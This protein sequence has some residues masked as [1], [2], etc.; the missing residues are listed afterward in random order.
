MATAAATQTDLG[1]IEATIQSYFDGLYEGDTDKLGAA[2]HAFA[3]LYSVGADG[4]A[5]DL[6]LAEW[7]EMVRNRPSAASKG[8]ARDDRIVSVDQSGPGTAFVKVRCQSRPATSPTTCL[9]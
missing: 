6:P 5:A 1:A 7:F 4:N 2:F 9:S 8:D 3:H